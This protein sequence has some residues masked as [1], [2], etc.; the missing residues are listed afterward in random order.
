M[1]KIKLIETVDVNE[2]QAPKS[3]KRALFLYSALNTMLDTIPDHEI[4]TL[5]GAK[6]DVNAAPLID[7]KDKRRVLYMDE[8]HGSE[9]LALGDIGISSASLTYTPES[10][11]DGDVYPEAIQLKV[12]STSGRNE[13]YD[14]EA[15]VSGDL[16]D[17]EV[18]QVFDKYK[19]VVRRDI[20]RKE[21][22]K[23]GR[24]LSKTSEI[25][26]QKRAL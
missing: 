23:I 10:V 12:S 19:S 14:M 3:T 24:I 26:K 21:A 1:H 2:T 9:W 11:L 18:Y 20:S 22:N 13:T 6:I 7:E 4:Q 17:V 5:Q 15:G 25:A 8:E 16:E